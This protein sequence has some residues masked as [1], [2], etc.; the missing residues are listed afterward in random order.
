MARAREGHGSLAPGPRPPL[1]VPMDQR[2]VAGVLFEL[3]QGD[4]TEQDTEAIVNA[5]N[6]SLL[7]GGG[8]DGA[9]HRVAGP[10]LFEACRVLSRERGPLPAGE[11]LVTPGFGLKCPFVIHTVGPVWLGGGRGEA[12]TLARCYRSVLRIARERALRSVAFPS[13]STGAYGYPIGKAAS[14]ALRTVQ[15]EVS[16][17]P[18]EKVRFVLWGA[19]DYATYA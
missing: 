19:A 13:I 3:V 17:S 6:S 11:A 12:E 16:G 5:A 10:A 18:L 2:S 1:P 8:V 4:L 9:I 14:V 7:G 15:A